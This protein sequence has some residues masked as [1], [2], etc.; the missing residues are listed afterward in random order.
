MSEQRDMTGVLNRNTKKRSDKSPDYVGNISVHGEPFVIVGWVNENKET[1]KKFI[2]LV[3]NEDEGEQPAR[4]TKSAPKSENRSKTKTPQD[5]FD[6][7]L[8]F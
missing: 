8:P 2:S 6:D 5:D 7:D 3:V 1:G 4:R